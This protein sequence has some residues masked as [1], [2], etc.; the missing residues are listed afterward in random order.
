M[1]AAPTLGGITYQLI[2]IIEVNIWSRFLASSTP[3]AKAND[4]AE[5]IEQLD[6]EAEMK[7]YEA[8]P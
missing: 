6:G 2:L 4:L 5:E 3:T 7:F 1:V 8:N